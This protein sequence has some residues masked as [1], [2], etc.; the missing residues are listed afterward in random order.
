MKLFFSLMFFLM[1]ICHCTVSAQKQVID[2]I[3]AVVDD[4]IILMSEVQNYAYFEAM[5]QKINPDKDIEAYKKIESKILDALINQKIL[6]AQ[7]VFDSVTVDEGQVDQALEQQIKD[8][9]QQAGG[10]QAL[11]SYLGKTIKELKKL[12][13]SDVKKQL[14]TQKIQSSRFSNIKVSRTDIENYYN[15]HKDSFPEVGESINFSHILL[16]IKPGETAFEDARKLAADI[17]DSIKKGTDFGA[18]AKKYS[19]DPGSAKKGGELG[20]FNRADFVKE[21]SEAAL[22]LEQGEISGLVKTQFGWH[23]IQL[24]EKAGDKIKTRHILIGVATSANDKSNTKEKLKTIRQ[25]ILDGKISFEDAVMKYSDDNTK[26]GNLG[27]LGWIELSALN[28]RGQPFL[29]AVKEIKKGEI[30]DPFEGDFGFHIIRLNDQRD[31]RKLSLKDDWQ[32]IESM[33]LQ[34]KQADEMNK[35]LKHIRSR[36]YIDIRMDL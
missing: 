29:K 34:S 3:A 6:L 26:K 1:S 24:Q 11:E 13:R 30:S 36:F 32:T 17:L 22:K 15:A 12:Y 27:N 33:A 2:K 35:W 23:I 8:R 7:A 18:M 16:E 19:S 4:E 25:D 21:Y 31:K 14:L 5:N 20:W 28:E 10:E 9:I